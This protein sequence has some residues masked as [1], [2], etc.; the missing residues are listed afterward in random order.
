LLLALG[1]AP[2]LWRTEA[3]LVDG[4]PLELPARCDTVFGV[5][6]AGQRGDAAAVA[7]FASTRWPPPDGA[8]L[9][10]LDFE[11]AALSPVL[12]TNVVPRLTALALSAH[13]HGG[14][15]LFTTAPL[16]AEMARV[17]ARTEVIDGLAA[18]DDQLLAVAA[19]MHISAGRVKIAADALAKAASHPLGLLGSGGSDDDPLRTSALVGIALA[20]DAGRSGQVRAA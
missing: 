2:A 9:L 20:L 18:E 14:T 11:V 19:A 6:V 1:A 15:R 16:A 13:A 12:L 17:G 10:L 5:L 4:R 3:L 8:R 7:Y